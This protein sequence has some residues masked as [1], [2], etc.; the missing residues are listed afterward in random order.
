MNILFDHQAFEY[1][2][3]GG[4]SRSYVE[5]ISHL[6]SIDVSCK[7][8]IKE[9]DNVY[10]KDSGLVKGIKP[11]NY[12]H[13]KLF[14][15]EKHFR[16]ERIISNAAMSLFGYHDRCRHLN[17]DYSIIQIKRQRFDV[18]EPTFF[19]PYFLEYLKGKPF[20][21]TV[22]DMIPELFP[23]YFSC[24]DFQIRSKRILCPLATHIHVPSENTKKDL[25]NLLNIPAEKITVIPHGAP[26]GIVDGA[27]L[28]PVID[29]PYLLYV[30]D[31]YGYKNFIPFIY[32]FAKV[33][34]KHKDLR[35]VCT[36]QPF[37]TDEINL[38]EELRI[39]ERVLHHYAHEEQLARLYHNAIAFI[40]PSLY[41]GFGI[42]ILEA[43]TYGC[44]V[45]LNDT[46]C[47][48]EI[49][50]DAAIYFQLKKG[51]QSDFCE[52]IEYLL[53]L[54][55]DALKKLIN[56]GQ[57]QARLFN[58]QKSALLLNNIYKNLY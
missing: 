47:F 44:P 34:V 39:R 53:H 7:I 40:F 19:D 23:E 38:F 35:L 21:L 43:F 15:G 51:L 12:T 54:S 48:S 2:K 13:N 49:A 55:Q 24:D 4:V 27:M 28:K 56:R 5:L 30:G 29:C 6:A 46:S 26:E 42:P 17:K 33:S 31:R 50:G 16:G 18:F 25:V 37:S 11:L 9:S 22:H 3:I 58:W 52:K 10:L 57:E 8:S 14:E 20:V 32:E 41:E 45:M 36:G 1:Q